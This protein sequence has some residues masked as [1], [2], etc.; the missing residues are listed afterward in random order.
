VRSNGGTEAGK[1]RTGSETGSVAGRQEPTYRA[2]AGNNPPALYFFLRQRAQVRSRRKLPDSGS[3]RSSTKIREDTMTIQTENEKE[4]VRLER[5]IVEL[6]EK[7]M[8]L[9]NEL[10]SGSDEPDLARQI[11]S[12]S[13]ELVCANDR[14]HR[15]VRMMPYL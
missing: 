2:R 8:S 12:T 5:K 4:I 10:A 15:F 14:L 9:K 13:D 11:G 3:G 1:R 7:L 6:E